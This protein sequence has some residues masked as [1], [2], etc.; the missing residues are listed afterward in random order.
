MGGHAASGNTARTVVRRAARAAPAVVVACGLLLVNGG[1]R[2]PRD[3]SGS[4][5][6]MTETVVGAPARSGG[7][8]A[9][10]ATRRST[11]WRVPASRTTRRRLDP[12]R[13]RTAPPTSPFASPVPSPVATTTARPAPPSAAAPASSP[14]RA[15]GA[16]GPPGW[17]LVWSDEFGG[18]TVDT[19]RW[20]I[21]D[22]ST[23]GDGNNELACLMNRP[24]NLR[25]SGGV[26]HLIA[27]R[28]A[29]PIQCGSS[30]ARF[31]A[32]RG[33]TSAHL[34]TK[35]IADWT[36]GR[37]EV[38]ARLPTAAG[39]SKGLW[40]AFW[41]RPTAGG[42]GELDVL[43]AIGGDPSA[44]GES[45]RVHQTIW[46]D[47]TGSHP[48][49]AAS[50]TVPN[51]PPSA[52]FHVYAAEW[53]PGSIRWYIDGQLTYSRT[54][55]TTPWLDEAFRAPFHLRLNLAVGG[56]WPGSPTSA[57]VLPVGYDVDYVRVYQR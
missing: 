9:L 25:V 1:L 14:P 10:G 16:P 38:R 20:R 11:P 19:S 43:E 21:E 3:V 37:F 34:S 36:Y 29:T 40:P 6:V 32:G 2:G 27:R 4:G 33:Y 13:G 7:V 42:L 57:T 48:R 28:E 41:L 8:R 55:A 30:D 18:T 53:E 54:T 50:V 39:T 31:P 44:T 51:G 26:L 49:E 23:Y 52:S 56:S 47:Y 22:H 46:Y 5:D 17:R 35:G 12:P 15:S 24:E 45:T